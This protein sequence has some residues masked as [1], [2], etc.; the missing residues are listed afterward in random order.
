[1]ADTERELARLGPYV[2]TEGMFDS[3]SDTLYLGRFGEEFATWTTLQGDQ[4]VTDSAT[5]DI[6]GLAI[7][8]C[9]DRLWDGPLEIPLR[10]TIEGEP[11]SRYLLELSLWGN[12]G[13]LS[14]CPLKGRPSVGL[15]PRGRG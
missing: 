11:T 7:C 12:Q 1:M 2:F 13:S 15:S 10:G 4:V 14:S 8:R 3:T 5:G 6:V 9:W